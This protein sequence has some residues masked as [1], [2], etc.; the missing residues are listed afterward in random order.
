[1]M[2][3]YVCLLGVGFAAL[4]I[5]VLTAAATSSAVVGATCDRI[6]STSGSDSRGDGTVTRPYRTPQRLLASLATGQT[7]CLRNGTY[8]SLERVTTRTAGITL[9]SYP[10]DRAT[11]RGKLWIAGG[12]TTVS[13][14]N[15]DGSCPSGRQ[16]TTPSAVPSPLVTAR[17]ARLLGN[18]I[19]DRHTGI[20]VSAS[21]YDGASPDFL[22]IAGNRIHDCGRLPAKNHDHG[23]YLTAGT[24]AVIANNVIYDN[25]DRGVQLYPAVTGARIYANTID[26]NGEGVIV[27][28]ASS[29]NQFD[30]N[31]ISNSVVRWNVEWNSLS[32]WLNA[33]TDNCLYATNRNAFYNQDGGVQTQQRSSVLLVNNKVASPGY[34]NRAAKDFR[35]RPSSPCFGRGAA[36]QAAL[37]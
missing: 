9:R 37:R 25:A 26:G 35:I 21:T 15:L 30:S 2:R 14:L 20:C 19:T 6:A 13:G 29:V 3:R 8:V 33:A 34:A 4:A 31:I 1:V 12:G 27:S 10:G 28:N 11:L 16:C 24:G 22:V 17:G 5:G 7:G 23:I 36:D 32:G 18:D